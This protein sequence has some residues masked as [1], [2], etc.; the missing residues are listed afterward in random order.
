MDAAYAGEYWLTKAQSEGSDIARLC[1]VVEG[2]YLPRR[3]SQRRL[4]QALYAAQDA[5]T[6]NKQPFYPFLSPPAGLGG[7]VH[8]KPTRTPSADVDKNAAKQVL[9]C[10]DATP[11]WPNS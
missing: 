4:T 2:T 3:T 7:T 10:F 6:T 11:G 5:E 1:G 9:L 8:Q